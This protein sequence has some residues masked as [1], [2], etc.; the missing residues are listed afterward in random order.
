MQYVI[1]LPSEPS[2]SERFARLLES[3]DPSAVLDRAPQA[4]AL[5][6]STCLTARELHVL[7]HAA[8]VLIGPAAIEQLPSECC[9]GCGG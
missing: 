8:G 6:V 9:G 7:A 2:D 4:P 5:R 3:E 1:R